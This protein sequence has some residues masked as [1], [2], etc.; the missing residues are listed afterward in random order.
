M[1]RVHRDHLHPVDL[2]EGVL[3]THVPYRTPTFRK[4]PT[5]P[6]GTGEPFGC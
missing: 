6:R 2:E 4:H 3:K 1:I 5:K